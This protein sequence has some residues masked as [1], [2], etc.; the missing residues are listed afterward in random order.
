MTPQERNEANLMNL[1]NI[2]EHMFDGMLAQITKQVERAEGSAGVSP[3]TPRVE[4]IVGV[5][6][7][8][9]QERGIA[10]EQDECPKCF[11]HGEYILGRSDSDWGEVKRCSCPAGRKL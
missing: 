2:G 4:R 10:A 8:R 9:P 11:G 7:N 1:W 3:T 5:V 6:A